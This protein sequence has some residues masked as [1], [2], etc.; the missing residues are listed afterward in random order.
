MKGNDTYY[1]G[2]GVNLDV[3]CSSMVG[4]IESKTTKGRTVFNTIV[5]VGLE[6]TVLILDGVSFIEGSISYTSSEIAL[7]DAKSKLEILIKDNKEL[8]LEYF[9]NDSN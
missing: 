1:L 2:E 9:K 4:G 7:R 5:W 6:N 8:L 3:F